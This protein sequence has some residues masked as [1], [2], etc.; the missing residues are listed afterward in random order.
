MFRYDDTKKLAKSGEKQIRVATDTRQRNYINYIYKKNTGKKK[1]ISGD[2]EQAIRKIESEGY[3]RVKTIES[4]GWEIVSEMVIDP[5]GP[6]K[7]LLN[8]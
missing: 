3:K 5:R 6:N 4:N 2:N 1:H 7:G 8:V